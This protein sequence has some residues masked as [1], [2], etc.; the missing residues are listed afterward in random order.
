MTSPPYADPDT[1]LAVYDTYGLGADN[2]WIMVGGTQ[3]LASVVPG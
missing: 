2:G 3:R 1:G